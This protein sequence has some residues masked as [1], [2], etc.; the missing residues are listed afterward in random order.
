VSDQHLPSDEIWNRFVFVTSGVVLTWE[1]EAVSCQVSRW[2][3]TGPQ[4]HLNDFVRQHV[5]CE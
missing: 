4:S 3:F 2:K 1:Q 5:V